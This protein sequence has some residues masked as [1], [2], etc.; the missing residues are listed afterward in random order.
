MNISQIANVSQI[1]AL[2]IG[3]VVLIG[4]IMPGITRYVLLG[5]V[6]L[7]LA[8]VAIFGGL[9]GPLHYLLR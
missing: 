7:L 5:G 8:D 4:L 9:E 6:V 1:A 3:I 2:T